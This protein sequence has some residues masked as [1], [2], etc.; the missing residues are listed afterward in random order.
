[1]NT[2]Q[3]IKITGEVFS[4]HAFLSYILSFEGKN[5]NVSAEYVFSLP[6]GAQISAFK[7]YINSK[8]INSKVVTASHASMLLSGRDAYAV[9]KKI[10]ACEYML[11]LGSVHDG[12]CD[13]LLTAY[14]PLNKNRII[15]PL[16]KGGYGNNVSQHKVSI[17]LNVVDGNSGD[18]SS[19]THNIIVN[20]KAD[21]CAEVLAESIAANRD[22]CLDIKGRDNKNS[23][24][25][26]E[27]V[28]GGEML[29]RVS[30]QDLNCIKPKKLLLIYD[31]DCGFSKGESQLARSFIYYGARSF[32]GSFAV[33]SGD[34]FITDGF[35][36]N[37]DEN[38]NS[39]LYKLSDTEVGDS[40]ALC[41]ETNDAVVVCVTNSDRV[42]PDD[43]T[44]YVS[45]GN[46][47]KLSHQHV[48]PDDNI[49]EIA[50][51]AIEYFVNQS[52]YEN[53][54]LNCGKADAE[55]IS[56][57]QNG[58]VTAYVRYAGVC[59]DTIEIICGNA[60]TV[61]YISNIEVY[62]SYLPIGLV[63]ADKR[64]KQLEKRLLS[65]SPEE[66]HNIR[67]EMERIG[68]KYSV[69]N[70]ETALAAAMGGDKAVIKTVIP[71][72]AD[73]TFDI[74]VNATSMFRETQSIVPSDAF[75]KR[76]AAL[77]L[78]SLRADGAICAD[79]ETDSVI[80]RRQTE[81]CLMAL[82]VANIK[83]Y[84][85]IMTATENKKTDTSYA[86]AYL[87]QTF[88]EPTFIPENTKPDLLTA[89]RALWQW[90]NKNL[91]N[92]NCNIK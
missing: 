73:N 5:K 39:L 37:N 17:C 60:K 19:P 18:I 89:A 44:Y 82:M 3:S 14:V 72:D 83:A 68:V 58:A 59:P 63:Y 86:K 62:N 79:G 43:K 87:A 55:L 42:M 33:M 30:M 56:I 28:N 10:N 46:I 23:A 6:E 74:G 32:D 38:I 57:S 15:L 52:A 34:K 53:I 49:P 16:T 12:K 91:K 48:Y 35:V 88:G 69:L 78:R 80:R 92:L 4:G 7:I 54:R 71:S 65:C 77:I 24:V 50:R 31:K 9:L 47:K 51:E 40:F 22:F 67:E 90:T 61:A 41:A 70:T 21:G 81:I 45:V 25:L 36:E 2:L 85:G 27:G 11:T 29:C 13:I 76:C 66:I 26:V 20:K 64:I 1:M 84:E 8:I 75:A